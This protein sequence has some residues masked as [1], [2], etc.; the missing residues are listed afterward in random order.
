MS[1]FLLLFQL[2]S[3]STF[4]NLMIWHY[5]VKNEHK[6]KIGVSIHPLYGASTPKKLHLVRL[7]NGLINAK[8]HTVYHGD[9]IFHIATT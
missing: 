2:S 3:D 7:I 8:N 9:I 5:A 1:H 6:K 4:I